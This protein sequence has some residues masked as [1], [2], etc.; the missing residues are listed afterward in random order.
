[1]KPNL[2]FNKDV[3]LSL[4]CK[5]TNLF[6]IERVFM[7][8]A[9]AVE[10]SSSLEQQ[11]RRAKIL[12]VDNAEGTYPGLKAGFTRVKYKGDIDHL[13]SPTTAIERLKDLSVHYDGIIT[14]GFEGDW[15]KIDDYIRQ[16]QLNIPIHLLTGDPL[17]H[18]A[19][20]D[21]RDVPVFFKGRMS[22]QNLTD[23]FNFNQQ[24]LPNKPDNPQQ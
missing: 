11:P 12:L 16:H 1:M 17:K 10:K 9:S 14:C 24:M 19:E 4:G 23:L 6:N 2:L 22:N 18:Q 3:F 20:A 21:E 5:I 8:E 13:E 7:N 15:V